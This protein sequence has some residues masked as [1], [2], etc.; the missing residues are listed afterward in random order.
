LL[1]EKELL[2]KIDDEDEIMI[3]IIKIEALV[4]EFELFIQNEKD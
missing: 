2:K 1:D 4:Q 3:N